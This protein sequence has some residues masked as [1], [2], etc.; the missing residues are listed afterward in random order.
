MNDDLLSFLHLRNHLLITTKLVCMLRK[1]FHDLIGLHSKWKDNSLQYFPS[2]FHRSH[3]CSLD[4]PILCSLNCD[5]KILARF[6]FMFLECFV[7]EFLTATSHLRYFHL[8][9][10]HQMQMLLALSSPT[11][12]FTVLELASRGFLLK[13]KRISSGY[14][15]VELSFRLW[16]TTPTSVPALFLANYIHPYLYLV[17]NASYVAYDHQGSNCTI[18]IN[19]NNKTLKHPYCELYISIKVIVKDFLIGNFLHYKHHV[20][21]LFATMYCK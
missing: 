15:F 2:L 8:I 18:K 21:V 6:I 19:V 17:S 10:T 5:V 20:D 1:L 9:N 7:S 16:L 13:F 3:P 14:E 11:L 12:R 4:K